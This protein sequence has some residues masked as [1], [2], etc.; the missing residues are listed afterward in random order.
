M[1]EFDATFRQGD[2][3]SLRQAVRGRHRMWT[4]RWMV[5]TVSFCTVRIRTSAVACPYQCIR[6]LKPARLSR[7]RYIVF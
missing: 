6:N 4:G 7:S 1:F 3:A 5:A 2:A